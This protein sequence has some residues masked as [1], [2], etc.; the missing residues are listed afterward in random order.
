MKEVEVFDHTYRIGRLDAMKQ[1]HVQ[2]RLAPI[3]AG[4][5]ASA[6]KLF[7][8]GK[9]QVDQSEALTAF[10]PVLE[11]LAAMKDDE[12]EYVIY[13]CLAVVERKDGDRWVKLLTGRQFQ[14]QDL[15]MQAMM[16]LTTE[17]V[18]EN[19]GGFFGQLLGGATPPPAS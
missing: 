12:V 2:R 11:A 9:E 18:E 6:F 10:A 13:T 15:T 5:G 3:L 17:V 1:L 16:R 4:L 14:Y 7:N 8:A 19:L